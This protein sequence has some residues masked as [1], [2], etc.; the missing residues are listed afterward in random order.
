M[1]D[2][3]I[4]PKTAFNRV[5]KEILHDLLLEKWRGSQHT[6]DWRIEA[7]ALVCLQT[8]TEHILVMVMEMWYVLSIH[9]ELNLV[10]SLHFMRKGRQ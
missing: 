5:V 3:L 7:D 1:A 4:I 6:P 9:H 2:K 8:M 10:K